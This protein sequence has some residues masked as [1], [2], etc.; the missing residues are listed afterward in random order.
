MNAHESLAADV[1]LFHADPTG[2]GEAVTLVPKTGTQVPLT[3]TVARGGLDEQEFEDGQYEIELA[4]LYIAGAAALGITAEDSFL[5]TPAG[6]GTAQTW[7]IRKIG[8]F[9]AGLR[10]I[11][12]V[13][14]M[15]KALIG[16]SDQYN[17]ARAKGAMGVA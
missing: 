14:Q 8:Y 16:Q 12:I 6:G 4:E 2:T 1:A 5:I 3:A 10:Q 7:K 11:L 9:N 13:R 15:R 17:R